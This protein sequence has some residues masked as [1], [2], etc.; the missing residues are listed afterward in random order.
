MSKFKYEAIITI[1]L[2]GD[3]DGDDLDPAVETVTE[4]KED[5]E[6]CFSDIDDLMDFIREVHEG[7]TKIAAQVTATEEK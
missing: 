4:A 1:T 6:S 5:L 7:D 3:I 2:S